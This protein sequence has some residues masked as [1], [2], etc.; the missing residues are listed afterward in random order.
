MSMRKG[1]LSALAVLAWTF[2][3]GP[4]K[5]LSAEP[6]AKGRA[7]AAGDDDCSE[8]SGGKSQEV[9][10]SEFNGWYWIYEGV[11]HA[12][13][14]TAKGK[15]LRDLRIRVAKLNDTQPAAALEVEIRDE[16]LKKIYAHGTVALGEAHREFRWVSPE[17]DHNAALEKGRRYVLLFH[18][19]KSKHNGGWLV[20]ATYQ[21]LYPGGRQ[22]GYAW[23]FFFYM[24]FANGKS[25]RVGPADNVKGIRPINSG[26]GGGMP[27]L[28]PLA[29]Y[30]PAPAD[31][32]A[33]KDPIG[34]LPEAKRVP[35]GEVEKDKEPEKVPEVF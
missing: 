35:G 5:P 15:T 4:G 30:F 14:F 17:L 19:Q 6:A 7:A 27:I 34:P 2:L 21:D 18:S 13:Y 24:S 25:V 32:I 1:I 26:Y 3:A 12:Q 22:I 28:K 10:S 16:S 23:D 33:R 20:N 9:Y 29:L 11:A 31:K 8:D